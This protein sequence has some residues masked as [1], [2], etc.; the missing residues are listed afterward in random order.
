MRFFHTM[1]GLLRHHHDSKAGQLI[2]TLLCR[3]SR[4]R[5]AGNIL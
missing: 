4:L 2:I 3:H 1:H 5:Y